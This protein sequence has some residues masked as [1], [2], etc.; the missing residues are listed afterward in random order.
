M[1]GHEIAQLHKEN[2]RSM[3]EEEKIK[4]GGKFLQYIYK[5]KSEVFK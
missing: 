1:S 3:S 5:S 2:L 4:S